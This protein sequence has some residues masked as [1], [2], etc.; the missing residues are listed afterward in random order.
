AGFVLSGT[1]LTGLSVALTGTSA[2]G[3]YLHS[4]VE[5]SA[6]F[7]PA[8]GVQYGIRP[9]LMPNLRGLVYAIA[10]ASPVTAH[11]IIAILS[12]IVILWTVRRRPSLPLALLAA[13][14]V[15]YHQFIT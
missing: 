15:S 13:L 8:H 4:L 5:M 12:G 1:A 14:L 3:T 11:I 10:T 2:F 9:E 7:S 6:K